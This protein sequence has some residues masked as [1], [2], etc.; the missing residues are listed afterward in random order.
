MN[1]FL[2]RIL[3]HALSVSFIAVCIAPSA[4]AEDVKAARAAAAK[5]EVTWSHEP[6]PEL[7]EALSELDQLKQRYAE[8]HPSVVAQRKRIEALK[9]KATWTV[10]INFHG[11]PLSTLLDA[12][13][14]HD[15][16]SFNVI[17][18][19]DPTDFA[20]TLPP[21][22]LR[23][24]SLIAT[25]KV[26][27]G[28]LDLRGIGLRVMD[29]S[30]PDAVVCILSRHQ[31]GSSMTASQP[32][33]FTSVALAGPLAHWTVD[34]IVATIHAAWELDPS[35]DPAALHIK[36]HPP[37]KMLLVSGPKDAITVASNV[38]DHLPPKSL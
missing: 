17:G 27:G 31:P 33:E 22:T 9:E 32:A 25:A 28:L 15:G 29:D 35:H 12:L 20:T 8:A 13:G 23:N 26:L 18:G 36:Y 24:A 1:K 19:S 5:P 4:K 2:L 11:G 34:E 10:S 14:S 38:I 6:S 37:T 16:G 7:K 21:F 3:T 30:T